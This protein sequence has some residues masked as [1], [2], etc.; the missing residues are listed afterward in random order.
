MANQTTLVMEPQ[1]V[2]VAVSHPLVMETGQ[3]RST[4][5]IAPGR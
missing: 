2:L 3:L 5:A 1:E 4:Q